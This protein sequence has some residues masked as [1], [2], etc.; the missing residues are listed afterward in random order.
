MSPDNLSPRSPDHTIRDV[1]K[2]I[3]GS[4]QDEGPLIQTLCAEL[5]EG[6]TTER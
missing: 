3:G 5:A 1:N 4:E 6:F 2:T